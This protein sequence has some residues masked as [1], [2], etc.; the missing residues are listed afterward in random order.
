MTR[1]MIII[2]SL[3]FMANLAARPAGLPGV[4]ASVRANQ[5]NDDDDDD[6]DDDDEHRV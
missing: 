2:L 6:D 1:R 3:R 4:P 5:E